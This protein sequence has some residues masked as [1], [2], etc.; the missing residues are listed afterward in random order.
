MQIKGYWAY[1]AV[2]ALSCKYW[3][4]LLAISKGGD[5]WHTRAFLG[6]HLTI[7][8]TNTARQRRLYW[9]NYVH[10]NGRC[11]VSLAVCYL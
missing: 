4:D 6:S 11:D 5:V 2:A 8:C 3:L 10:V 7:S 9:R 1:T